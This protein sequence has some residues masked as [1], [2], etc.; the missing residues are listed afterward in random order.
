M[1][2]NYYKSNQRIEFI[3]PN[4][5]GISKVLAEFEK[6]Y[7]VCDNKQLLDKCLESFFFEKN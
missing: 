5:E 3:E 1:F 6:L 2:K 4:Y 7:K